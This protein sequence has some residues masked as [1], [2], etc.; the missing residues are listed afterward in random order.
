MSFTTSAHLD[1][2]ISTHRWICLVICCLHASLAY[3]PP[4]LNTFSSLILAPHSSHHPPPNLFGTI[5]AG[6][7][8]IFYLFL[9]SGNFFLC[10]SHSLPNFDI[11]F[12]F[13]MAFSPQIN[14]TLAEGNGQLLFLYMSL[15]PFS[16]PA[17]MDWRHGRNSFQDE[18]KTVNWHITNNS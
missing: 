15:H 8:F 5:P 10:N 1:P 13:V 16:S 11:S 12:V 7:G 14:S 4:S 3:Y 2:V 18:N 17:S 6:R 9:C